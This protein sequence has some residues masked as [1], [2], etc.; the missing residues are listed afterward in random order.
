MESSANSEVVSQVSAPVDI[1]G[2]AT[3]TPTK[4]KRSPSE[5]QLKALADGRAKLAEMRAQGVKI[6][7]KAS[8]PQ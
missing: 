4:T 2:T 6:V 5:A 7:R 1:P 3:E 8:R